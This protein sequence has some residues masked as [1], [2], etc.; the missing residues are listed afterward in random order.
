VELIR[1][2]TPVSNYELYFKRL[3]DRGEIGIFEVETKSKETFEIILEGPESG[4]Y[5]ISEE[6]YLTKYWTI[7]GKEIGSTFVVETSDLL[8]YF[9]GV[10]QKEK[11][12]HYVVAT[13]SL[14]LEVLSKVPP[15]IRRVGS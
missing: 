13:G 8:N 15:I 1:W 4:P 5:V 2:E 6:E 7:I 11:Y 10:M 9:P 3:I 14:C 12:K